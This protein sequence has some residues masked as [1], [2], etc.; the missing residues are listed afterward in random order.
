MKSVLRYIKAIF[1][2]D[3]KVYLPTNVDFECLLNEVEE[4]MAWEM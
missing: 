1:S 3:Y 4:I 2:Q